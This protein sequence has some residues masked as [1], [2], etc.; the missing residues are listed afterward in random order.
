MSK[1]AEYR[2]HAE[3][4][5]AIAGQLKSTERAKLLKIAEEWDKLA[6][7]CERRAS[8]TTLRI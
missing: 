5:R 3:S 6:S 1:E 4:A 8:Q 2:G 7:D